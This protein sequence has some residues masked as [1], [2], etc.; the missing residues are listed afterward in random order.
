MSE[1]LLRVI[2]EGSVQLESR[3]HMAE[4]EFR[5]MISDDGIDEFVPEK[6]RYHLFVSYA[7]PFSHYVLLGRALKRLQNIVS[8]S[9]VAPL[10]GARGWRFDPPDPVS[11]ADTLA[12]IYQQ[13]R[14]QYEGRIT[15][16][17]L[18]DKKTSQIVSND[19]TD[20]F[21]ML[22]SAFVRLAPA[23]PRLYPE[24]L[25]KSLG[26]VSAFIREY[27]NH[28]VYQAGF[29]SD[30]QRYDRAVASLFEALDI[31]EATFPDDDW[32][33]GDRLTEV[34]IRLFVTLIRF[35]AVYHTHF[36]CNW[37]HAYDYPRLW[38]FARRFYSLPGVSET[39]HMKEILNH[40]YASQQTI[41][42]VGIVPRGPDI[43]GR[44]SLSAY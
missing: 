35:D 31:L 21:L 40:Y 44:L 1:R 20:I 28:G 23:T 10:L 41:N 43:I 18:W 14:P 22:D 8:V 37:R 34:D 11:R 2:E 5:H 32:L 13:T 24:D 25:A 9:R 15:V 33:F 16:P 17:V 42:P 12:D 3:D 7:C 4:S 29:A 30:Q 39:V 27:I 26:K 19:S 6:G 36:K 38:A